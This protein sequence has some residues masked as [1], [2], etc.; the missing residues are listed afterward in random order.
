MPKIYAAKNKSAEEEA[1]DVPMFLRACMKV[2]SCLIGD[3][4]VPNLLLSNSD[5]RFNDINVEQYD[6]FVYECSILPHYGGTDYVVLY[7]KG[8]HKFLP[9]AKC[10]DNTHEGDI[11]W[12]PQQYKDTDRYCWITV[13]MFDR[14]QL[15]M[16]KWP[17]RQCEP[18]SDHTK[19]WP[20][21]KR[22]VGR[23][24]YK[25]L[26]MIDTFL[27]DVIE[28]KLMYQVS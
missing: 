22:D 6:D 25:V 8:I 23:I 12:L 13:S 18:Q 16:F 21:V 10:F 11:K 26:S 4:I 5:H 27:L 17:M 9:I 1:N 24:G 3:I 28:R 14:Q 2:K 15:A 7:D 20:C 19:S